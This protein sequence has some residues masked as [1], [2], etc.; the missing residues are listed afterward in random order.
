MAAER[1]RKAAKGGERRRK[2]AAVAAAAAA[3]ELEHS[4]VAHSKVTYTCFGAHR[5]C[6]PFRY[7]W[8]SLRSDKHAWEPHPCAGQSAATARVMPQSSSAASAVSAPPPPAPA[9]P[10]PLASNSGNST[11]STSS[12]NTAAHSERCCVAPPRSGSPELHRGQPRLASRA[13]R[14][15]SS[16]RSRPRPPQPV[17]PRAARPRGA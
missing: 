17:R 15:R 1:R 7:R 10:A 11:S 12:S 14:S 4:Q 8:P 13:G 2:A 9:A 16:T 6:R 5:C 3:A